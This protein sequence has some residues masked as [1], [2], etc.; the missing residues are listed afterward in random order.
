MTGVS[1]W[2]TTKKISAKRK[3]AASALEK[4]IYSSDAYFLFRMENAFRKIYQKT[5]DGE[6][7]VE[8]DSG[9]IIKAKP[10]LLAYENEHGPLIM[11]TAAFTAYHKAKGNRFKVTCNEKGQC[12]IEK[13]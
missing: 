3:A 1:D 6:T 9:Y 12:E 7:E 5:E 8:G 13:K 4:S 2:T 10:L 11:H